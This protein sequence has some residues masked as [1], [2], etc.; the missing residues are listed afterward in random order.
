[1]G[2][3]RWA[4]GD[5]RW[6]IGVTAPGRS[7]KRSRVTKLDMCDTRHAKKRFRSRPSPIAD[8]PSP[9][10]RFPSMQRV[11]NPQRLAPLARPLT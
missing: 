9:S 11:V 2:D 3:G 7:A 1:M 6:A 4:M 8:R 10:H 5:G